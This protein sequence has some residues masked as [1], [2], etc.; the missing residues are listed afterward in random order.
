MRRNRR[1]GGWLV[2]G[3]TATSLPRPVLDDLLDH[4]RRRERVGPT[5]VECKMSDDLAGFLFCQPIIHR[6]VQMVGD[7][8]DLAGR[9]QRTDRDETAIARCEPRPQPEIAKQYVSR[10]LNESG[11]DL[12]KLL[13][14]PR[15]PLGLRR[16]VERELRTGGRRKLVVADI[17][18]FE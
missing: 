2:D 14:N 7:L 16:L 1:P 4:R 17:A 18:A 10:V 6:P 3:S 15:R 11:R 8:R 5:G 9:D 13:A 12:S